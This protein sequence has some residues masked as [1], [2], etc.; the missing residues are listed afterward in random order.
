MREDGDD[1]R[2]FSVSQRCFVSSAG[3]EWRQLEDQGHLLRSGDRFA[4]QRLKG[5]VDIEPKHVFEYQREVP[6]GDPPSRAFDEQYIE[7]IAR[8]R[9][10][11][12]KQSN[13]KGVNR[14]LGEE[15][16]LSVDLDGSAAGDEPA[17]AL[18]LT[19]LRKIT[20]R[21]ALVEDSTS[22]EVERRGATRPPLIP[23]RR[24]I[25]KI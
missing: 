2:L 4:L 18:P 6:R 10:D 9:R 19:T 21:L 5:K 14:T 23:P 17:M 20:P 1:H 12:K 15:F 22:A 3:G 24:P 25:M 11:G 13:K 8:I 16:V 7:L